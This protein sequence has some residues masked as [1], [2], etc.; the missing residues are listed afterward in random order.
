[1]VGYLCYVPKTRLT[2]EGRTLR[3]EAFEK[4]VATGHNPTYPELKHTE[5][6]I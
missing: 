3:K 2:N 4:E 1:M 5:D 6:H